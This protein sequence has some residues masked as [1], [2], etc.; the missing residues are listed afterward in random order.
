MTATSLPLVVPRWQA[1]PLDDELLELELEPPLELEELELEELELDELEPPFTVS[2]TRVGRPEPEPQNPKDT[3]ADGGMVAFQ[4]RG[5]TVSCPPDWVEVP[6][7][8]WDT[9]AP[10]VSTM[11]ARA[12]FPAG[13]RSRMRC[14]TMA[15]AQIAGSPSCTH[16]WMP[17]RSG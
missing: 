14:R 16:W 17:A 2:D 9:V 6:L 12:G 10:L 15:M 7:Q 5:L 8:S 11:S 4:L 1:P 13:V 3:E